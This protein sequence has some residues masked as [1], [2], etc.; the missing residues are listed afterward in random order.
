MVLGDPCS[1]FYAA[2]FEE[3]AWEVAILKLVCVF[4][5]HLRN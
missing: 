3:V 4:D 2:V 5:V 1:V